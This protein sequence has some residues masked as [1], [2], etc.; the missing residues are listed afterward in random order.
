MKMPE[1]AP[2]R[3]WA[4]WLLTAVVA[5]ACSLGA[6]LQ[7]PARDADH[8]PSGADT[9]LYPVERNAWM[10]IPRG[11]QPAEGARGVS[12]QAGPDGSEAVLG[13]S[14]GTV[15][16]TV[17]GGR[18][19]ETSRVELPAGVE[20]RVV[21]YLAGTGLGWALLTDGSVHTTTGGAWTP[22]KSDSY[23]DAL[24]LAL[25]ATP[26][27]ARVALLTP[28]GVLDHGASDRGW[29]RLGD[30]PGLP[31]SEPQTQ[32]Q[33]QPPPPAVL[34]VTD[35][36]TYAYAV[37]GTVVRMD[38]SGLATVALDPAFRARALQ[39]SANGRVWL[40]GEDG[41][42]L[43][44]DG[45]VLQTRY[46]APD[47]SALHDLSLLPDGR[48]GWA[49]GSG[50]HYVTQDGDHWA[51]R[52]LGAGGEV[53]A[54]SLA[55]DGVHGW[56]LSG[57]VPG[58]SG[59]GT[60]WSTGDRGDHWSRQLVL[61]ERFAA[62]AVHPQRS[63]AW[64]NAGTVLTSEDGGRTWLMLASGMKVPPEPSTAEPTH[65]GDQDCRFRALVKDRG[66]ALDSNG[67]LLYTRDGGK[68]WAPFSQPGFKP[69]WIAGGLQED[70]VRFVATDGVSLYTSDGDRAWEPVTYAAWPAPWYY[71]SLVLVAGL[72][73]RSL[74][75]PPAAKHESVADL[76]VTDKPIEDITDDVLGLHELAQ[77]ISRFVRN[78]RTQPSLT[79]AVTG[80][81]GTGKSSL[82][83]L[84][85][86]DLERF[87]YNPVWFN[88]WHHEQEESLIAAL[89]SRI[90]SQ[91]VP[92]L[93]A[94]EAITFRWRLLRRQSRS[95]S[96]VFLVSVLLLTAGVGY[97]IARQE[98]LTDLLAHARATVEAVS[99]FLS[100]SEE[101][102]PQPPEPTRYS[103]TL[104]QK[105][106]TWTGSLETKAA[107][108]SGQRE[109]DP[110]S[111]WIAA[112]STVLGLL[113]IGRA[114]F[115]RLKAFGVDPG[116]LAASLAGS[117]K[118]ADHRESVGFHAR[119]AK[120]FADVTKALAPRRMVILV[121]DLDRCAPESTLKVLEAINFLVTSGECFVVLAISEQIVEEYLAAEFK[122]L[123]EALPASD[124]LSPRERRLVYARMYLEKLINVEVKLPRMVKEQVD[125]LLTHHHAC[126]NPAL[127][128]ERH[129][130]WAAQKVAQRRRDASL[131]AARLRTWL[132][133]ALV[134][135]LCLGAGLFGGSLARH[136]A[137][138]RA[139]AQAIEANAIAAEAPEAAA[140]APAAEDAQMASGAPASGP[141]RENGWRLRD[142]VMGPPRWWVLGSA[143]WALALLTLWTI[144]QRAMVV[145][146]SHA[147]LDALRAWNGVIAE[148]HP[149][150]RAVKRFLNR[151]RFY[152]MQQRSVMTDEQDFLSSVVE[153]WLEGTASA[154][155]LPVRVARG[156]HTVVRRLLRP[157]PPPPP[158]EGQ[159]TIP[160]AQLVALAALA[161]ADPSLP[162]KPDFARMLKDATLPVDNPLRD[163]CNP[164]L[165]KSGFPSLD[166]SRREAMVSTFRKLSGG[167][168]V[169]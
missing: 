147:F 139:D 2:E 144:R 42:L 109:T 23:A 148:K 99:G 10:R 94:W 158:S 93:P 78:E 103:V 60:V 46:R 24:A 128:A 126:D 35:E 79:L 5:F 95:L 73:A 98:H 33:I 7:P 134:V 20:L 118:V 100:S 57:D 6:W 19:W 104:E 59:T 50:G 43:T 130:R 44:V 169:R 135:G 34:A 75:A 28:S 107:P 119:F 56:A 129:R 17:N 66:W 137:E 159:P 74:R 65:C 11:R 53:T 70:H 88:A 68:S 160:E 167:L 29:R 116:R 72:L 12:L 108:A 140:L 3:P 162:R 102:P 156:V 49:V 80:E 15:L 154:P 86:S 87:G 114:A 30:A 111:Q 157:P 62:L 81:W 166:D 45:N 76:L 146:D 69:A 133:L 115:V 26:D 47:S 54:I 14:D 40:A 91:G 136:S 145:R 25:A 120:D 82:L 71:L 153:A 84:L 18:S 92:A 168:E 163:E 22:M 152:A 165:K 63:F 149:T 67:G 101:R 41:S 132:S 16:R 36:G 83:N 150:P 9:L 37:P 142:P 138:Q 4:W 58:Q 127:E 97:F 31:P 39:L 64:T 105:G 123:S 164:L 38:R 85:K 141:A 106:D 96:T 117:D 125:E 155:A 21:R 143:C 131:I 27:G 161:A 8:P 55:P 151:V 52:P 48:R 61:S 89:Y 113:G 110:P 32:A 51:P 121:D 90:I 112:L 1:R 122:D 77:G 13:L 124:R